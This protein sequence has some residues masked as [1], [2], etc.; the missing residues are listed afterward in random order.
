MGLVNLGEIEL[1]GCLAPNV[2]RSVGILNDED[3]DLT[4][5]ESNISIVRHIDR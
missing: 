1:L 3:V 4:I 2:A 5:D